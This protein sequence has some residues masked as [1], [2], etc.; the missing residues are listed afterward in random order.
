MA[1]RLGAKSL[2][3]LSGKA[4]TWTIGPVRAVQAGSQSLS[5]ASALIWA[6]DER[7]T[8]T[9]QKDVEMRAVASRNVK[10]GSS[11]RTRVASLLQKEIRVKQRYSSPSQGRGSWSAHANISHWHTE[12]RRWLQAIKCRILI[13]LSHDSS[14]LQYDLS[15]QLCF[16]A[17][18]LIPLSSDSKGGRESS[19]PLVLTAGAA[20]T[21]S[22]RGGV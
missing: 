15:M 12:S 11:V 10:P 20:V 6:I 17:I 9:Q 18:V 7:S 4:S 22:L 1:L 5:Q 21:T 13:V 19:E 2:R 3:Q 16:H 8:L 14:Q